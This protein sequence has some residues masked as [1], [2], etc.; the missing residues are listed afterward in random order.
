MS[1]PTSSY[2]LGD[3]ILR[4]AKAAGVAYYGSD[5][6]GRAKVPVDEATFHQ[7]LDVVND[8]IKM[9]I[10]SAP[11][12]GWRWMDRPASVTFAPAVT[13]TATAGSSTTLTDSDI[14][15]DYADDAF[16]GYVLKITAGTGIGETATVT[17]F[18][19]TAG[20]FTFAALSGG[21][22]PDTT[23]EYRICRSASVVDADPARYLLDEGFFGEV[24]GPI[25]YA[26][27][28]N[29]GHGIEWVGEG[30]IRFLREVQV[31]TGY[32]TKAAVR[33]YTS[34]RWELIVDPAPTAADSVEFPYRVGFNALLAE[35]G[36]ATGGGD[37]TL[38][39]SSLAGLYPNDHFNGWTITI[40][41]GTG[42]KSNAVVTDYA[43][44]SGTFTVAD[45]LT[46]GG[47][48]GGTNPAANSIYFVSDGNKHPAG[49]QFDEAILAACLAKAELEFDDLKLGYMDK[50]LELDLKKAYEI[51]ARSAPR[52]L[53]RML[54]GTRRDGHER[55]WNTVTKT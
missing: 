18:D 39:D 13:G 17:D 37:T 47:Q 24:T 4:V 34:R 42:E 8:G 23:S 11:E 3:L 43:G 33:P 55:I 45:W 48:A 40:I 20:E 5:G 41:D 29:R 49:M 2:T 28:S 16:N 30:E 1:E 52:K 31:Q 50:F 51:D 6:Q 32:P 36:T 9:F 21:S 15:G 22:T 7:C 10:A 26:A 12:T 35:I 27:N 46:A 44:S 54:P 19:G 38:V 14:A 25:R 53:G